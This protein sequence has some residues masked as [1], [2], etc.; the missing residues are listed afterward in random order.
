MVFIFYHSAGVDPRNL[1]WRQLS[2]FD[3]IQIGTG[4]IQSKQGVQCH[5]AQSDKRGIRLPERIDTPYASVDG[6]A[7]SQMRTANTLS[8]NLL[9]ILS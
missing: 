2:L 7:F 1:I 3:A 6:A 5:P 8:L 9:T 4:K